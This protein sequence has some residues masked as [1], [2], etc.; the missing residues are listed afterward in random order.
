MANP[1]TESQQPDQPAGSSVNYADLMNTA[2]QNPAQLER[3]EKPPRNLGRLR[4][5]LRGTDE[6]VVEV[7]D[8]QA[9]Q[10]LLDVLKDPG[11]HTREDLL[12]AVMADYSGEAYGDNQWSKKTGGWSTPEVQT[13]YGELREKYPQYDQLSLDPGFMTHLPEFM[14]MLEAG[15]VTAPDYK[16]A[17]EQL[18]AKL[19]TKTLYRGTRLTREE[20]V[21]VQETGLLSPLSQL[22]AGSDQPQEEFEALALSPW[23]SQ[24]VERHFHGEHPATPFLSVSEHADIATAVGRHYGKRGEGREFYLFKLE[25][26]AIDVVAYRDHAITRPPWL[27]QLQDR[28]PDARVTVGL[29]G[30]ETA[31]KWDDGIESYVFGKVNPGEIV[32]VTQPSVTK[33]KWNGRETVE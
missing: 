13:A 14:A 3:P 20:L 11:H 28:N 22:A 2:Q 1:D 26:P 12:D 31:H 32:E 6:A 5:G 18:K 27:Q 21:S 10:Q 7:G 24:A 19:G 30:Q 17:R 33:S 16:G 9:E 15:E 23:V 4:R 8:S 29:D 25:V